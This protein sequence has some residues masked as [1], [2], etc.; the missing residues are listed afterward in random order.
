MHLFTVK[1]YGPEA[2]AWLGDR[3]IRLGHTKPS[4]I[5]TDEIAA[6]SRLEAEGIV[7]TRGNKVPGAACFELYH[8]RRINSHADL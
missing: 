1:F 4:P 2:K 7:H 5:L 6:A 3:S 8:M